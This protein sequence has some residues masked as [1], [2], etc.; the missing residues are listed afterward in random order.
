M[1]H[2]QWSEAC[3]GGQ[4]VSV[5]DPDADGPG[6][7]RGIMSPFAEDQTPLDTQAEAVESKDSRQESS[8]LRPSHSRSKSGGTGLI[9]VVRSAVKGRK[10][11]DKLIECLEWLANPGDKYSHMAHNYINFSCIQSLFLQIGEK[12]V[13]PSQLSLTSI[14]W[15]IQSRS[16]LKNLNLLMIWGLGDK[17][18]WY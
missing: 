11:G 5:E 13:Q 16:I 9:N 2:L 8:R 1:R 3:A 14:D 7:F 4:D 12:R 15:G 17:E 10:L 6:S 18:F